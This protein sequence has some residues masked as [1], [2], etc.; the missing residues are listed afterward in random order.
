MLVVML[1]L[2]TFTAHAQGQASSSDQEMSRKDGQKASADA[3]PPS[4]KRFHKVLE[5]NL[6]S[7]LFVKSNLAPL[8]IGAA[9]ALAISPFDKRIVDEIRGESPLVGKTGNILGGPV[10]FS[11]VTGGLLI[12]TSRSSRPHFRSFT[13]TFTQAIVIDNI[14][15]QA[16]KV[17]VQRERPNRENFSFP[18]GHA[19]NAFAVATVVS[20]Y[21]GR[22]WGIPLFVLSTFVGL[23]RLEAGKHWPSD[24]VAGAAL[25][26]I[27]GSTAIR[28]T[29]REMEQAAS[30]Q[31]LILPFW[32]CD[33]RG[34]QIRFTF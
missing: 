25:G 7:N 16:L 12:A 24:L 8:L 20:H 17:S 11:A 23:S 33:Y 28:G 29:H 34:V 1:G 13:Y 10:L 18:S 4:F 26:Y 27:S 31:S 21:Y 15:T 22:K 19:S 5:K 9:G 3:N 2:L 6:T 32:N 14:L 30:R